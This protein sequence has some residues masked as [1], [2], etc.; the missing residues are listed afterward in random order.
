M[1]PD[2]SD[3]LD[4]WAQSV[5]IKTVTTN[6]V[7]FIE[8]QVVAGRNQECV[9]QV[10]DKARLNPD[11]IDWSLAYLMVHSKDAISIGE[12]IEYKGEDFKVID[13]NPYG[14]YGYN[15][16]TAEQTKRPV[17]QVTP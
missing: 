11:T 10:A 3:V 14:D 4:E 16:V 6:K 17:L 1:L 2:M 12:Y 13:R 8:T 9:V 5:L 15:E 7:N